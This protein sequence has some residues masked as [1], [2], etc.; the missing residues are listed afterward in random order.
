[1][2]FFGKA[3]QL[4]KITICHKGHHP[5]TPRF[6]RFER[7]AAAFVFS[8]WLTAPVYIAGTENSRSAISLDINFWTESRPM[9]FD[10]SASEPADDPEFWTLEA[11]VD[12]AESIQPFE[13]GRKVEKGVTQI[14]TNIL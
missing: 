2:L 1:L 7:W 10:G 11:V 6:V 9:A 13:T 12:L 4:S 3:L 8:Q 14:E 5:I